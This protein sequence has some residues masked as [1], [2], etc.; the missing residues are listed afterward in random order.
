MVLLLFAK[1]A[2]ELSPESAEQWGNLGI[3]LAVTG[4]AANA[5]APLEKTLQLSKGNIRP[6]YL[7]YLGLVKFHNHQFAA[8]AKRLNIIA[9]SAARPAR[10]CSPVCQ[11]QP[12]PVQQRLNQPQVFEIQRTDICARTSIHSS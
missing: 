7:N 11:Y 1:Q 8:A 2:V 12:D 4:H 9:T 10:T 6:L 5:M 3:T